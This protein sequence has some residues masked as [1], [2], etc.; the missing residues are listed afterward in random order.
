MRAYDLLD[1]MV[2]LTGAAIAMTFSL[3][4]AAMAAGLALT[5][6]YAVVQWLLG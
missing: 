5:A 3:I 1:A 4:V 6:L 2:G